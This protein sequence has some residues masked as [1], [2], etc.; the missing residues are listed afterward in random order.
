VSGL[1]DE[2][3]CQAQPVPRVGAAGPAREVDPGEAPALRAPSDEAAAGLEPGR[4]RIVGVD[5]VVEEAV[6]EPEAG[7]G[8]E[9]ERSVPVGHHRDGSDQ[10]QRGAGDTAGV[11]EGDEIVGPAGVVEHAQRRPGRL[12]GGH[13][14]GSSPRAGRRFADGGG[15]PGLGG[16]RQQRHRLGAETGGTIDAD[17]GRMVAGDTVDRRHARP[18]VVVDQ[19]RRTGEV[20][21]PPGDGGQHG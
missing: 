6:G 11:G 17:G 5:D 8:G 3:A 19:R 2:P 14:L 13:P 1:I 10:G 15:Q 20:A 4:R 21:V 12:L 9:P 16:G 18:A 7:E